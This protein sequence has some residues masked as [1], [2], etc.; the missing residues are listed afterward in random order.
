[1]PSLT[2]IET[3]RGEQPTLAPPT[4]PTR[5][6]ILDQKFHF[7]PFSCRLF[8]F[9]ETAGGSE[10]KDSKGKTFVVLNCYDLLYVMDKH[11][12]EESAVHTVSFGGI[13]PTCHAGQ[14]VSSYPFSRL[15]L[16][17]LLAFC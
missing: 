14:Q 10:V 17:R 8:F 13:C 4:S 12:P 7:S 6:C 3:E 2:L 16:Q 9:F 15:E 5:A 11:N 1:M